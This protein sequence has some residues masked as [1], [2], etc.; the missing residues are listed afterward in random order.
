VLLL[1]DQ[2]PE[3][4]GRRSRETRRRPAGL[5]RDVHQRL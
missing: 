5:E 2:T 3:R 1:V 4:Q